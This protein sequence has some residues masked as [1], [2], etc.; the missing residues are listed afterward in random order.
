VRPFRSGRTK[1][2]REETR[3]MGLRLPSSAPSVDGPQSL[4]V[5]AGRPLAARCAP[6]PLLG[7]LNEQCHSPDATVAAL[8]QLNKPG[9]KKQPDDDVDAHYEKGQWM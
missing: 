5:R 9:A 6:Y 8:C 3:V 1:E 4:P 2:K 7:A